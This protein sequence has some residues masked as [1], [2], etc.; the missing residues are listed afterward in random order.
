M[1]R[2]RFKFHSVLFPHI[3]GMLGLDYDYKDIGLP[4]THLTVAIQVSFFHKISKQTCTDRY[5]WD[6]VRPFA[7]RRDM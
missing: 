6:I 4:D 7:C 5:T 3:A 1:L 2:S